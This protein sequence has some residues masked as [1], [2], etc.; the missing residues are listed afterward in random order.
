MAHI[1]LLTDFSGGSLNACAYAL[2]LFGS[3]GNSFTLVHSY[4]DPVPGYATMVDMTSANYAASVEGLAGF[5]ERFRKLKGGADVMLTTKVIY[6]PLTGSLASACKEMGADIIVMGTQGTTA[7]NLFGSSAGA[8]AKTSNVPVLIVPKDA[9]FAGL[10]RILLADDH[11]RVE[12]FALRML[13]QLAQRTGA[14]I[15]LAHV[16]RS[17]AEEPDPLVLADYDETL[18][19]VPHTYTSATGDDVALALSNVAERDN[20]DLVAVLHRHTGFLEGLFHGSVAKHLAMH[21]RI[22]LLVLEH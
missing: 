5:A 21:T 2:D 15:T 11:V 7:I 20:M 9:H 16:L 1:L 3:A 12:P 6:G 19:L 17:E 4:M 8:V 18:G 10:Q 22:P 14:S 13:V